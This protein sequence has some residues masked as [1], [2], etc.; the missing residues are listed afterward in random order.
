MKKTD[1]DIWVEIIFFFI[2]FKSIA[3][4]IWRGANPPPAPLAPPPRLLGV[5]KN[6]LFRVILYQILM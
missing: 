4:N 5:W 3:V 2:F 1:Y 6:Q